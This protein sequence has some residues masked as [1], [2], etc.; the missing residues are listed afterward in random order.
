MREDDNG[1]LVAREGLF[2]DD[3]DAGSDAGSTVSIGL[4]GSET[5]APAP[6]EGVVPDAAPTVDGTEGEG[7]CPG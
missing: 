6:G 3:E 5:E 4:D 7:R 1:N 2:P